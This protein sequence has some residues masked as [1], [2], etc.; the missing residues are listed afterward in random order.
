MINNYKMRE[1]FLLYRIRN[2]FEVKSKALNIISYTSL[3]Q[4]GK[5]FVLA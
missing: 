5:L 1:D 2:G 3:R 4:I